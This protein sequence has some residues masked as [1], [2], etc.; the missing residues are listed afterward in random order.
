MLKNAYQIDS[1]LKL[2]F[3]A[4]TTLG[5]F[6]SKSTAAIFCRLLSLAIWFALQSL[7]L[8]SMGLVVYGEYVY[9]LAWMTSLAEIGTLGMDKV[10]LRFAA[11]YHAKKENALLAGVLR[12]SSLVASLVGLLLAVALAGGV[13]VFGANMA[14]SQRVCFL[15]ASLLIP[16]MALTNISESC[17]RALG[18]IVQG[19]SS[20]LVIPAVL[21]VLA[22]FLLADSSDNLSSATVMSAHLVAVLAALMLALWFCRSRKHEYAS[23]RPPENASRAWIAMTL[24]MF[25]MTLQNVIQ[26]QCGVL[27]SGS[28]LGTSQAGVYSLMVKIAALM[29]FGLQTINLVA[30]PMFAKLHTSGKKEQ[31]Q[32][33]ARAC[34]WVSTLFSLGAA[35]G[36]MF[37]WDSIERFFGTALEEG[38]VCLSI[39][40]IG[41]VVNA[42]AGSVGYLLL[43]SGNHTICVKVLSLGALLNLLLSAVLIPLYGIVGAAIAQSVTTSLWNVVLVYYVHK[44]MDIWSFLGRFSFSSE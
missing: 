30:A 19:L 5:A 40:A 35:A 1:F 9:V 11:E 29:G 26:A 15:V 3:N 22:L 31:L 6:A 23:A 32:N 16:L 25:F 10:V 42:T 44:K 21:G 43:M 14:S 8:R 4:K 17:L 34:A 27:L 37:F 36:L 39:L 38:Q 33:L 28:L 41:A 13:W 24:P 7:L 20:L 18:H 12:S 2:F